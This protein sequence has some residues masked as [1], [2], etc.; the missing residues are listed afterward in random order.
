MLQS[1]GQ[2]GFG[3]TFATAARVNLG[4][5]SVGGS[6][7]LFDDRRYNYDLHRFTLDLR[8]PLSK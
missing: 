4:G 3:L 6:V 7:M 5:V 8:V 1:N 2:R